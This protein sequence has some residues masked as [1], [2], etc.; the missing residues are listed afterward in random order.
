MGLSQF[1]NPL[2]L[3][4]GIGLSECAV[5]MHSDHILTYREIVEKVLW[6]IV[7]LAKRRVI[8]N[9]EI[10]DDFVGKPIVIQMVQI[11]QMDVRVHDRPDLHL[12]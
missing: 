11:P 2:S 1:S 9:D 7:T 5:N 10:G 12:W 8:S 6:K 3:C 4:N